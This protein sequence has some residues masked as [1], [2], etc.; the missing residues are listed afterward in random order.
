[1]RGRR[2]KIQNR[3]TRDK[4]FEDEGGGGSAALAEGAD[5]TVEVYVS[6][7]PKRESQCYEW[8]HDRGQ[9]QE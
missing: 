7:D 6:E 9:L 4:R 8:R 3:P 1:M 2:E 5:C